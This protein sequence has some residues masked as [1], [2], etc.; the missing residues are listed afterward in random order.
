MMLAKNE[1]L[2]FKVEDAA[3]VLSA[4]PCSHRKAFGRHLLTVSKALQAIEWVDGAEYALGSDKEAIRACI[5][6]ETVF[7]TLI[8][9]AVRIRDELS[10]MLRNSKR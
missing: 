9:E 8:E 5:H 6:P 3:K 1:F 7:S 10:S 4:D 2:C